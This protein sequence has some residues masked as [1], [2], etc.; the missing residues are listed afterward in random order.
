M[1]LD[2]TRE[3]HD[4]G[5]LSDHNL[6]HARYNDSV[7]ILSGTTA[8]RPDADAV[9]TGTLYWDT[10]TEQVSRSNGTTWDDLVFDLSAHEGAANPHPTYL[11][12]AEADALYDALGDAAAAVTTHEAAGDP[13][14]GYRLESADHSHQS[15]G[16]QAGQL[17]HGA[18]LT[19]L[20]DDDHPQ[21]AISFPVTFAKNGELEVTT[22]TGAHRFYLE[23][24]HTISAVQI[25]VGTAPTG[26]AVIVDVHVDGTTIF[27]TQSNRPEIAIS[28]FFDA[29]GTIEDDDHDDGQYV[30]V[31]IDQI[32]STLPGENLTVIVWLKR[33]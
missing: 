4:L 23:G 33:R 16:L 20:S 1:P 31:N 17:D 26:A 7:P 29:S 13:H 30:T 2:E 32:G 11:T 3:E 10:D 9:E 5:H 24:N 25:S 19:G 27:T 28:G 18:A 22:D 12:E 15:T 14:T 8:A 21:Y 6:L